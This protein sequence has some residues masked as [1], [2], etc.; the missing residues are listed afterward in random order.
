MGYIAAAAGSP[1]TT[2]L[3]SAAA[4]PA[5]SCPAPPGARAP[6]DSL[7]DGRRLAAVR[8][9]GGTPPLPHSSSV[10][11]AR[12]TQHPTQRRTDR[13]SDDTD[14]LGADPRPEPKLA[15]LPL[16]RPA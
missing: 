1:S 5:R 6:L 4:C 11:R 10:L 9:P 2:V 15:E 16:L 12:V 7:P 3:E 14:Q 8:N 13:D